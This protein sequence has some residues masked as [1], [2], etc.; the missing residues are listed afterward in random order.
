MFEYLIMKYESKLTL[1]LPPFKPQFVLQMLAEGEHYDWGLVDLHIPEV[2]KHTMGE[3]VKIGI[4]DSGM[5]EHFEVAHAYGDSANFTNSKTAADR[6]GHSTFVSGIIGAEHNGEGVIG[7]APKAKLFYAKAI[8]DSGSGA[9]SSVVKSIHWCIESGV[10]IIS[11]SAGMFID[12]KPIH[13]AVKLAFSKNI[14]VIAAAGNSGTRYYDIAFP[15]RY[16]EVIGVGAYDRG[17]LPAKFSS[18]GLNVKFTMPGVD[19]YSTWLNNQ[20]CKNQGTSFSAPILTGVCALIL[21]KHKTVPSLTPCTNVAQMLEHLQ[22][23][24]VK[25]E[26]DQNAVGMGT[27]NVEGVVNY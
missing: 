19:I 5:S 1:K 6:L 24:A 27:I 15:A 17:R 4:I 2:H 18:R 13:N 22:R 10:D 25:V 23:Y 3:N 9:P 21:S 11:I 26:G 7:V 14:I 12:F 8:N 20:Y 16:P